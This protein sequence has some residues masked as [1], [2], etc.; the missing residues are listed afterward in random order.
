MKSIQYLD[1]LSP[2]K[3]S[4]PAS[5]Y[6]VRQLGSDAPKTYR[7]GI[8]RDFFYQHATREAQSLN[9]TLANKLAVAGFQIEEARLP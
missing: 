1:Q 7:I 8:I 2:S 9:D 3:M 6:A 4:A 5:A